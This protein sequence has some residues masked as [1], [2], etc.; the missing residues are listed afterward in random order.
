MSEVLYVQSTFMKVLLYPTPFVPKLQED[1]STKRKS[2]NCR[3]H[4]ADQDVS[5][6]KGQHQEAPSVALIETLGRSYMALLR[7][8]TL[9]AS[10]AISEKCVHSTQ[11]KEWEGNATYLWVKQ[12]QNVHKQTMQARQINCF[13]SLDCQQPQVHITAQ[14]TGELAWELPKVF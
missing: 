11:D 2:I 14:L 9:Q 5:I 8:E 13:P 6:A 3:L 4:S 1:L 10:S 12:Y 7:G